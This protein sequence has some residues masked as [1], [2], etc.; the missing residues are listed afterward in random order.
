MN[1]NNNPG[2][3][4][5]VFLICHCELRD[6]VPEARIDKKRILYEIGQTSETFF[7]NSASIRFAVTSFL[8]MQST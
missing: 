4:A 5:R 1:E 2:H 3:N 7:G 8:T 6:I